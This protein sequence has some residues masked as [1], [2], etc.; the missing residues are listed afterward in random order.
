MARGKWP[1]WEE[2]RRRRGKAIELRQQGLSYKQI[3]AIVGGSNAS[4][5]LW[6]RDVPLTDLQK[7]RLRRRGVE[8]IRKTAEAHRRRTREKESRIRQEALRE[9]GDVTSQDL[10]V[11]GVVAYIAEGTKT[12]PWRS[13]EQCHFM[14]SDPRMI[15]LFV[16]WTELLGISRADLIFRVM[17]HESADIPGANQYWAKLLGER[18][19]RLMR[20]TLKHGN[21]KTKRR[22]VGPTYRGCLIVGIRKSADLNRRIDGWFD[23]MVSRTEHPTHGDFQIPQPQL[24]A[25][26]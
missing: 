6:L 11:A 12:K 9:M 17:I 3:R 25:I 15:L 19:D 22:N 8:S 21:P 1:T 4:M 20:P 7:A 16:R 10:F 24:G 18:V 14:N 23:A 26:R 13:T 2:S 5:S